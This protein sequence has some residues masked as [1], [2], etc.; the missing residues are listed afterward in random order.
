MRR[1]LIALALVLAAAPVSAQRLTDAVVPEH[2]TLWFAPDLAKKTFRGRATIRAV[3]AE[4]SNS[5]TLH[6]AELQFGEVK[7]T[8]GGRTQ[9]ARVTTNPQAETATF[10][11][12]QQLSE[13]PVTIEITYNGILNDK[14][15]GFYLSEA[16]GRKYAVSQMEATD[17]RRAF[18]SFDEPAFKATF[19]I[20]LTVDR[21]D[22]AISNGSVVS[23]TPGPDPDT[24][25]IVYS[26]TP[27][28]STYL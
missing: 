19:D 10:T 28:M 20:S 15:R 16:N 18:P 1:A 5:I 11:V 7:I 26:R 9:V 21:A 14:L 23:D 4:R 17:A 25:T 6:S 22:T 27:K 3:V 8:S 2:Y 24:H 13:G 12:P